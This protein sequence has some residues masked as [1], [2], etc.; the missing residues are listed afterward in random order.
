MRTLNTIVRFVITMAK[1]A[2]ICWAGAKQAASE[3]RPQAWECVN[4]YGAVVH[5]GLVESEAR[6]IA[7]R[8][9]LKARRG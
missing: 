6:A 9:G 2:P 5:D 4:E 3:G 8:K 7:A 1:L